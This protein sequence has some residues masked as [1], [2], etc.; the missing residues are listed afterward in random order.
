MIHQQTF[1]LLAACAA[2]V[3]GCGFPRHLPPPEAPYRVL[4]DIDRDQVARAGAPGPDRGRMVLETPGRHAVVSIV[5]RR[6]ALTGEGYMQT[7][8]LDSR[9]VMGAGG[10]SL[11]MNGSATSERGVCVTPCLADLAFGAHELRLVDRDDPER[12]GTA[13]VNVDQNPSNF[14]YELGQERP[15]G[16]RNFGAIMIG[17]TGVV[18]AIVGVNYGINFGD[19]WR[20]VAPYALLGLGA[21]L[22]TLGGWLFE[23]S[24]FQDG[25]GVQWH[26]DAGGG[27]GTPT[28]TDGAAPAEGRP[29][30]SV[31]AG[32]G[33]SIRS[34]P[35][36]RFAALTYAAGPAECPDEDAFRDIVAARL[37][38]QPFRD[39][40]ALRVAIHI[41]AGDDGLR[42]TVE[43]SAADSASGVRDLTRESDCHA[44]AESVAAAVSVILSPQ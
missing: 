29:P 2:V 18:S 8:S 19:G 38:Y 24:V 9:G 22:V 3:M 37:G 43:S 14:R 32:G 36:Q 1:L 35:V 27:N 10:G 4:T 39:G 33:L 42:A 12:I 34:T 16:W 44:L 23:R 17:L 11:G 25:S 30:D 5:E 21:G 26:A 20:D 13:Y 28:P 41:D 15:R 6:E 7:Y 40:E 31:V